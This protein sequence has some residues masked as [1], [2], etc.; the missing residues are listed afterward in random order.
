MF[1]NYILVVDDNIGILNLLYEVLTSDGYNV[2][3][4]QN[5]NEALE[6][7]HIKLPNLILLDVKMPY[8]SG[9]E[10][11]IKINEIDPNIPIII[12]TA[13]TELPFVEQAIKNKIIKHY[14][15]K[16]FD[17]KE[18]RNMIKNVLKSN[19]SVM[20]NAL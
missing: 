4:A 3:L 18:L 10:T 1:S 19:N 2:E 17:L 15:E 12:I 11:L 14:I 9:F 13:Y 16:P 5:G 6:K 7:I 20:Q 8:I